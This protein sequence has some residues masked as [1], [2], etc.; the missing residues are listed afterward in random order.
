MMFP[1][2]FAVQKLKVSANNIGS[3]KK[4]HTPQNR[5]PAHWPIYPLT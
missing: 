5:R 1:N 4:K 2:N 3:K